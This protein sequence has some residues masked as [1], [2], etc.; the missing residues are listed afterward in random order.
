MK[1]PRIALFIDYENLYT[2]L[3]DTEEDTSPYGLPPKL[4]I[5]RLVKAI[6][7]SFGSLEKKDFIVAGNPSHY[8]FQ[9]GGLNRFA[10]IIEVD[11]FQSPSARKLEQPV[12]GM[13]YV[14]KNYTDMRL[15]MEIG[16]HVATNPADTYIIISG[17][18][19][20]VPVAR[21]LRQQG[22]E[23]HFILPDEHKA[24][25]SIKDEFPWSDY[26][27]LLANLPEAEM[28]VSSGNSKPE[29]PA[30]QPKDLYQ[31]FLETVRTFRHQLSSPVPL[32]LLYTQYPED[33]LTELLTLNKRR[34]HLDQR[35]LQG[36]EIVLTFR[37]ERLRGEIPQVEVREDLLTYA[38]VLK[39]VEEIA[40]LEKPSTRTAWRNALRE[41]LG[42]SSKQ[43]KQILEDLQKGKILR[44]G[45][46]AQPDL[47][48]Q[49]ICR[50]LTP[51][52]GKS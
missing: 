29:P 15:A 38:R 3:R 21:V 19:D 2:T 35:K 18:A 45:K 17:D 9:K 1:K 39:A 5:A 26:R 42:L 12:D 22:H 33:V 20:F 25:L 10:T 40:R 7:A 32:A 43:S 47:D 36:G 31:V 44:P 27:Q 49:T 30:S 6:H 37:T 48:M 28:P 23:V 13:K 24:A 41:R 4:D 34:K 46:W 11:S 14:E 51:S 8:D 50:F 52:S 16:I